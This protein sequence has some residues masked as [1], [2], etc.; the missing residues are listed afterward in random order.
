MTAAE[1]HR[2]TAGMGV[3]SPEVVRAPVRT[4]G[5]ADP[6]CHQRW[7]ATDGGTGLMWCPP[8]AVRPRCEPEVVAG[9]CEPEVVRAR[10]APEVV[11]ARG[12]SPEAVRAGGGGEALADAVHHTL[13]GPSLAA[14]T[15][16]ALTPLAWEA[17]CAM[18]T[19]VRSVGQTAA[20]AGRAAGL[21][22]TVVIQ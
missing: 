11:R 1:G 12:V 22:G 14:S 10:C 16:A 3:A 2:A 4:R 17:P 15:Q 8:E 7:C 6:V 20:R 19:G 13:L 18:T 21:N 5:G 9:P